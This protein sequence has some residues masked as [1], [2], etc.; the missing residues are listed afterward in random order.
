MVIAGM[1]SGLGGALLYLSDSGKY[2]Q[3]LDIIAPEGFLG[4][5]VALLGLS[6][7]L[8]IFLSGLFIGHIT[9]G[10]SNMQLFDFAPEAID[11][12]I[13]AIVYCGALSLLFKEIINRFYKRSLKKTKTKQED[14]EKL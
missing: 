3:V 9:V 6:E 4:I 13:A 14:K 11:M 10:G 5:S 2:M 1:L 12:I 7:P 8:G